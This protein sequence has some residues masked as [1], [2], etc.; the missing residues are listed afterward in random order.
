MRIQYG[1]FV[2][3]TCGDL[4]GYEYT[5][6]DNEKTFHDIESA[7]APMM[8]SVDVLNVNHHGSKSATNEKWCSTLTPTVSVISCGGGEG[9]LP[10]NRP[11]KNLKAINSQVYTTGTDCNR[12]HIVKYDNIIEM[13]DDVVISYAYAATTFTVTNS[14]GGKAKTY[15]VKMNKPIPQNCEL[16]NH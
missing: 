11:L 10:S 6:S 3:A 12:E 15:N 8:G 9:S 16:L 1:E 13:G 14:K 7:V 4:S 2:Y 5:T